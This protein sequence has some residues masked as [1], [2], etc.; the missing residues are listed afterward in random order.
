[1]A[2]EKQVMVFGMDDSEH[3]YYALDWTLTHLFTPQSSPFKLVVVHAKP[4]PAT[5]I[6]LAGPGKVLVMIK[7]LLVK[8]SS[9][10]RSFFNIIIFDCRDISGKMLFSS[11]LFL[12]KFGCHI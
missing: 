8:Y 6:G 2:V 7:C 9:I 10:V 12:M 11:I 5:A 4:S 3:S 1:M